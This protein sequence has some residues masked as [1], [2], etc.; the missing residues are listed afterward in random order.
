[1]QNK[2]WG[3]IVNYRWP[4]LNETLMNKALAVY[5]N[6]DSANISE[7]ERKQQ[8]EEDGIIAHSF[9]TTHEEV[10]KVVPVS[11]THLDVYKRQG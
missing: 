10:K 5:A 4:S 1:M 8:N 3:N 7:E 2:P 11:Y 9:Q 6:K